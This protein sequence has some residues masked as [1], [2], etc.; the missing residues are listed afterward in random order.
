M[1]ALVPADSIPSIVIRDA[2]GA[3]LHRVTPQQVRILV[4]VA[5]GMSNPEIGNVLFLSEDTIK[6]HL[7][8]MM[9]N[10]GA[11]SRAHLVHLA[12][13][14]GVLD[15]TAGRGAVA[16]K[17]DVTVA[18]PDPARTTSLHNSYGDRHLADCDLFRIRYCD[19]RD[20]LGAEPQTT[21]QEG[22]QA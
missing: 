2:D 4:M 16:V 8:H 13:V 21:V 15:R 19:C 1:T 9:R 18:D 10:L 6:T 12:H 5:D 11:R 20:R 14:L 17:T 22:R 3:Q 7:R